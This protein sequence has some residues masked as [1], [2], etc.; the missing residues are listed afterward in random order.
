MPT[1]DEID[2]YGLEKQ[3][4]PGPILNTE[5]TKVALGHPCGV[6]LPSDSRISSAAQAQWY[7]EQGDDALYVHQVLAYYRDG[8]GAAAVDEA[9][10][11]LTCRV[12]PDDN[13]LRTQL[14]GMIQLPQAPEVQRQVAY[15]ADDVGLQGLRDCYVYAAHGEFAMMLDFHVIALRHQG[16]VDLLSRRLPT[17][18]P[19][20]ESS[21]A[22]A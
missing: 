17:L 19:Q 22:R 14:T 8:T 20:L 13:G 1:A 7:L 10:R 9:E 11:A 2:G 16:A 3:Q 5:N 12:E 18:V 21:L 4:A 15:C 6:T